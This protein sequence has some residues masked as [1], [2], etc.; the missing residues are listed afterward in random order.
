VILGGGYWQV[1]G[2]FP[3][4]VLCKWKCIGFANGRGGSMY[5]VKCMDVF[6]VGQWSVRQSV[7]AVVGVV[8]GSCMVGGSSGWRVWAVFER[9]CCNGVSMYCLVMKAASLRWKEYVVWSVIGRGW[10]VWWIL[11]MV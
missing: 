10:V 9:Q 3:V 4:V 8:F 1:A 11:A 5:Q 6:G 2:Q 7:W